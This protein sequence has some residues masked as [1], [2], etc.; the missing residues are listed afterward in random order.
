MRWREVLRLRGRT[1]FRRGRVERE[2]DA[3]LRFHLEQQIA[4]NLAAG[5][6]AEEARYAAWRSVGGLEQI[7]E[8]CRDMRGTSWLEELGNDVRYGLRMLR[9]NPGFTAAVVLTLTLGIGANTAIFTLLRAALWKPLPVEK[10]Q[11]IF[12]LMRVSTAG[13]FAGEHS[14][15]YPL[16]QQ[17]ASAAHTWGEVFA[18]GQIGSRKFGLNALPTERIAGEDVS[19]NFFS[20]LHVRPILGRVFNPQ[21]DSVL[22]GN[23]VA[24]L[25]NAFWRRRFQSDP[26]ILGRTIYCDEAPYTVIGVAQP[27][28]LGSEAEAAVDVWV[29]VTA[30]VDKG[31]MTNAEVNWLRLLVR[32]HPGADRARAQAIF[33]GVFQTH[34]ANALLPGASPRWKS[35]LQAQHMTLRP[36]PSGLATTGRKYQ[37]PL[38][39]L[40]AVTAVVLLIACANIANLILARNTARQHEIRV[41]LALGASRGRIARQLF[42]E[43]LILSLTG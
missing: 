22:G 34:V 38:L 30:S 9:R 33:E 14:I 16:F 2:L 4:E 6:S 42:T 15:S 37:K 24:V 12:H 13:D 29:P 23:H 11:E 26:S 20:V 1:L 28:F 7:K 5:M 41:R 36:A 27:G 17:F 21:D 25:S 18:T 8:E 35:M 43:N 3:E 10:P 40:L 19:G 31:W 32:L 39:V